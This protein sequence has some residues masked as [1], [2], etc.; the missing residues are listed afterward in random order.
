MASSS[1]PKPSGQD[2]LE[3][4]EKM[5]GDTVREVYYRAIHLMQA[6]MQRE[7]APFK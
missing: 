4:I 3:T 1:N 7:Q 6:K 5:D 2:L